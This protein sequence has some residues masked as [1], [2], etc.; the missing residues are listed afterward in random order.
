MGHARVEIGY[1]H[2][3]REAPVSNAVLMLRLIS[4]FAYYSWFERY[5]VKSDGGD[6]NQIKKME[7]ST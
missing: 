1:N 4:A 3:L 6:H 2:A 7:E 5:S